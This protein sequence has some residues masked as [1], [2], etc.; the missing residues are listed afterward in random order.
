[1]S[2][3]PFRRAKCLPA[4]LV[5]L[6]S[7]VMP[8]VP[9]KAQQTAFQ[10]AGGRS[11]PDG[12]QQ[13]LTL[14]APPAKL[15]AS[16]TG[17]APSSPPLESQTAIDGGVAGKGE[18]ETRMTDG[19]NWGLVVVYVALLFALPFV[20]HLNDSIRAYM[21]AKETRNALLEKLQNVSPDQVAKLS[22]ELAELGTPAGIPGTTRSI[23][24]Y[25][26]LVVLGIAVFHLLVISP[27]VESRK[28]ADKILTVLAGTVSSLIGFYFGSKATKEGAG[29][30]GG[31]GSEATRPPGKITNVTPKE[32][33]A[34]EVVTIDGQGFGDNEGTVKFGAV[35]V[36][37]AEG[38]KESSIKVKVPPHAK[39]GPTAITVNPAHE[40]EIVG[41]PVLFKVVV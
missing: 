28:Y 16:T 19:S 11:V 1:M 5:L 4:L 30:P 36:D 21:F 13:A 2:V 15:A 7:M 3:S 32:A 33:K 37:K 24:T 40:K 9:A 18:S 23:F 25:S 35:S 10:P 27:D 20:L 6:A 41:S 14:P 17:S 34:G 26:L 38:W 22:H 8:G 31:Q 12:G 29:P 39:E